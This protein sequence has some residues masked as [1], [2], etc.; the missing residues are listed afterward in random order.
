MSIHPAMRQCEGIVSLAM[1][2]LKAGSCPNDDN[3]VQIY[4]CPFLF[5][6]KII[7]FSESVPAKKKQPKILLRIC[8]LFVSLFPLC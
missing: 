2:C 5:S 4:F 8:V 1:P 7:L 6:T 3:F